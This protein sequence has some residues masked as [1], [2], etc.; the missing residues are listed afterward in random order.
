[1]SK[2]GTYQLKLWVEEQKKKKKNELESARNIFTAPGTLR[3]EPIKKPNGQERKLKIH[4]APEYLQLKV[5]EFIES[6]LSG[7]HEAVDQFIRSGI[8]INSRHSLLGYT[9]LHAAAG[10]R[11]PSIIKALIRGG[12][13]V[14]IL[15]KVRRCVMYL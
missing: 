13:D 8:P 10:L 11:N 2:S 3:L 6:C 5:D 14:Q 1:M 7:D 12:A 4:G 15:N 9:A